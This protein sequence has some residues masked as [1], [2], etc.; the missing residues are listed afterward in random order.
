M[1]SK[2]VIHVS[3]PLK[4]KITRPRIFSVYPPKNIEKKFEFWVSKAK[5][6]HKIRKI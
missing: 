2:N 6:K 1:I 5:I 4:S 3:A